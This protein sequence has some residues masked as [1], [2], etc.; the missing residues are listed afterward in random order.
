MTVTTVSALVA[1]TAG[2]GQVIEGQAVV[3][4]LNPGQ[5]I[6]WEPCDPALGGQID[7]PADTECG[8]LGVPVDWDNPDG[9]SAEIALIK[10][11]ATGDK[12]GSLLVNPGG[13]GSSGIETSIYMVNEL[14]TEVRER[15]DFVGFDP[16]GV[17]A[18]TPA[19]WC[20]SD[21]ENDEVR[22]DPPVEYTEEG[23]EYLNGETEIFIQRCVDKVGEEFLANVGTVSVAKDLDA[24]RAALG[25][26]KLTYLGYS[27]GTRIGYTYAELFPENVGRMILDGAIDPNADPLQEDIDQAK[28]FQEAFNDFAADCAQSPDCPLGTDPTKAVDVYKSL[29]EPLAETPATTDDP[30]N[31]S[32]SDAVVGTLMSM[33]TPD[34]W[35]YLQ[36]GLSELAQGRGDLLLALSDL[37][38]QRGPD[39]KYTNAS[40]AII[41]INCVDGPAITDPAVVV[42][43]DRKAREAAPFQ[44]YGEFTGFAPMPTCAMWP[45]PPTSEP[46]EVSVSGLAPTLV[47]SVTGDPATPYQAGVKLA[48]Q[49]GGALLTYEGTQHTIVFQGDECVDTYATDYLIDGTLPPEGA[50]CP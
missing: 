12:V 2:C 44:S 48:E 9:E 31:L 22:A 29:V 32:Y 7:L 20:N 24:L 37:Y 13:P 40:D 50:T 23:V 18:S 43:Q 35:G 45:V 19:I 3:D 28:A 6:V 21:A 25:D 41:A 8:R 11:P 10:F 42:E 49:L 16:R 4:R 1:V 33:Y 30:R 34:Y 39:G 14:P 17:G 27:Y 38:Y 46:H 15:F 26:D 36:T 47:V 5:P